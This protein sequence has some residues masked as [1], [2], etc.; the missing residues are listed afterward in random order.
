MKKPPKTPDSPPAFP[1]EP[2]RE[3]APDLFCVD[4]DWRNAFRRR[5]TI[6]RLKSRELIVHSAIHL[7][8]EDYRALD[9]LGEVSTIVVPNKFHCSEAFL[10]AERYPTAN[11]LVS[12][13][14][15][16]AIQGRCRVDGLL[17]T[18]WP[19]RA[20]E[21]VECLSVQGTRLLEETVFF[22]RASKS[23]VTTDLVFNLQFEMRGLGKIF[24]KWNRIYKRFGPSNIFRLVFTKDPE[25]VQESVNR[26][27]RWDFDR[28]IMNHGQ[29]LEKGG[30][31]ALQRGFAEIFPKK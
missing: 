9:K 22:H 31:E 3:I 18:D 6:M 4:G 24:G 30:R 14:A 15:V 21:E 20:K 28:V 26:I 11:V 12:P 25:M 19:A 29:I 17:P 1:Y 27:L 16:K 5:M 7:R 10:Y 23:L 13:A 2:I 8:D